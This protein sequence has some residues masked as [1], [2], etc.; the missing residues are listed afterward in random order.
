MKS[1]S[2]FYTTPIRKQTPTQYTLTAFNTLKF[3]GFSPMCIL[4][5]LQA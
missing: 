2:S 5:T 3:K 1:K 4:G